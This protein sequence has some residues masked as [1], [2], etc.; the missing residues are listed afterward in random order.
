MSGQVP[1]TLVNCGYLD[2]T[3]EQFPDLNLCWDGR[4]TNILLVTED[5][6]GKLAKKI[7]ATDFC[8]QLRCRRKAGKFYKVPVKRSNPEEKYG[9][10][11]RDRIF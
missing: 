1:E 2:I 3:E 10:S 4:N 11:G 7:N 5:T 6:Y 9:I 8:C